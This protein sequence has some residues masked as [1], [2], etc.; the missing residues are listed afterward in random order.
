MYQDIIEKLQVHD[1]HTIILYGFRS[2]GDF[3]ATSDMDMLCFRD[4]GEAFRIV[5]WDESRQ[6]QELR[7]FGGKLPKCGE[8]RLDSSTGCFRW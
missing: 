6:M 4:E 8:N 1:V 2:R 5:R 7:F 3:T